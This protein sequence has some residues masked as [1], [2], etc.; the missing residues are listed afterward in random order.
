MNVRRNNAGHMQTLFSI[1]KSRGFA[2][3]LLLLPMLLTSGCTT[4]LW[5]QKTFAH[6]YQP[7]DPANLRLFYSSKRQDI[8]VQYDKLTVPENTTRTRSYWLGQYMTLANPDREPHFVSAKKSRGLTPIPITDSL[9][10]S[11]PPDPLKLFAVA[12]PDDDF[13]TLYLGNGPSDPY[14]LPKYKDPTQRVKQIAL[15][16]MAVGT[17]VTVFGAIFGACA[18]VTALP[19]Y[20]VSQN[21]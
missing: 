4:A 11:A 10:N 6:R 12:R 8:L 14:Q 20:L 7:A 3:A 9:T 18:A 13:F 16:P 5:D 2:F 17:D 21:R 19:Q 1:L 15:T